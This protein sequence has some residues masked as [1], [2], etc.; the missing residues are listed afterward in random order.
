MPKPLILQHQGKT[1]AL[2]L[3]KVDRDRLYG[4]VDTEV[5][6]EQGRRCELATLNADGKTLI[7]RGGTA[8]VT[9]SPTGQWCERSSLKAVDVTGCAITPV[10]S[11]FEAPV[12][13]D[14]TAT[15][16]DYLTHN[17]Q[18]I[19]QLNIE[20]DAAALLAELGAGTIYAFPF[21]YRGGLEA[22]SAF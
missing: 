5:L 7:G 16:D 2:S 11:S 14:K 15:V 10:K 9:L 6:D 20:G 22:Y 13:L 1:L 18:Y 12:L 8:V 4:Y 21:S 3:E 19:Y 17:I